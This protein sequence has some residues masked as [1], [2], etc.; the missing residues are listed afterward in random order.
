M[1][2]E[3]VS[4][5][6]EVLSG[7]VVNT[8]SAYISQKLTEIGFL[9]KRHTVIEDD[10]DL[11]IETLSESMASAPLVITT[12]GLGPTV[13]DIT[14]K[15]LSELFDT[16]L[17]YNEEL[18]NEIKKRFGE[19]KALQDQA[20]VPKSAHILPNR[21]GSASG[22]VLYNGSSMVI[23]LPG[24]PSEVKVLMEE[25]VI[26]FLLK[27]FNIVK[28]GKE[29]V[30]HFFQLAESD[31]DPFLR[32]LREDH[33]KL[34]IGIYP[35]LGFLKVKFS[36][37][38]IEVETASL[39]ILDEFKDKHYHSSDGS[40]EQAIQELFII[41]KWT[42]SVAESCTGG[43]LAAALTKKSGCS[44]YFVGGV[45]A[46][47]NDIKKKVLKVPAELI[48][49][50]GA[51]SEEVASK[52]VQ[53]VIDLTSSDFGVAITGIAGPGGGSDDKP[54]GTVFIA[55]K[56]RGEEPKVTALKLKGVRGQIIEKSVINTLALLYRAA[57]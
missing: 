19:V 7:M 46:Y 23:S 18:A 36:G 29:R 17:E 24:V 25:E 50:K 56:K 16:P 15:A 47:S 1:F 2:V 20:T 33:P 43:A 31:V 13:D 4:I 35:S 12:G 28:E 10:H 34:K 21:A 39:L 41:N 49:E 40:L 9:I 44:N 3:L 38:E 55:V 52:M 11:I 51:V 14:R 22:L 45:L 54:I 48:E 42:L 26:P 27:T 8:N 32:K 6:D 37:E 53:G 5:G 57:K 30:L